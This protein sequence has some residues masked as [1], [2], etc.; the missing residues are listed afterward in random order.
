MFG[1]RTAVGGSVLSVLTFLNATPSPAFGLGSNCG[2]FGSNS[3]TCT[4]EPF[5]SLTISRY[6][7]SKPD[8][9]DIAFACFPVA[10]LAIM[11]LGNKLSV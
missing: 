3:D 5:H 11:L 8:L 7:N 10:Y 1:K 4:N 2:C 6:G 9:S